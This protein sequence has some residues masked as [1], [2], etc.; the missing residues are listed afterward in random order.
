M[1]ARS[2]RGK[3]SP[4]RRTARPSA[5]ARRPDWIRSQTS[6]TRPGWRA[7]CGPIPRP[8]SAAARSRSRSWRSLTRFSLTNGWRPAPPHI[9]DRIEDKNG[10]IVW[11]PER[12]RARQ[13]VLKPEIAYEV[14]SCLTDALTEGTGHL[15]YDRYGL[16]NF[17][18][19]G[20]TGTAYDFTDAHLRRLRFA[21]DLRRLGRLRQTAK[22]L[23]RRFRQRPRLAGLG[24]H[25]ECCCRQISAAGVSRPA[26][27]AQSRDLLEVRPARDRQVL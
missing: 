17:P 4:N 1:R 2:R 8:F 15:A 12:G 13:P 16:K 26:G 10:N 24:R 27:S 25:H 14:T 22:N 6:C 5:S 21:A 9:L 23:P 19:A 18:A 20:K 7:N 11:Q 3:R